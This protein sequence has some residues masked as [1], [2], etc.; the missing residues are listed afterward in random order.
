MQKPNTR[1]KCPLWGEGCDTSHNCLLWNRQAV[2]AEKKTKN[3]LSD[4]R[5]RRT[6]GYLTC[7][8]PPSN[9]KMMKWFEQMTAIQ[10]MTG[11]GFL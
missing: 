1:Q 9:D 6:N 4:I 11:L 5:F 8:E 10:R 3:T 7:L 2:Y